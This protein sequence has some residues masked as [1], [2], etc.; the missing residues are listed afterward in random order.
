VVDI[1]I[2]AYPDGPRVANNIGNLPLH[3]AAM[4]QASLEILDLLLQYYR[5]AAAVRNTY[6][7]LPLHLAASNQA[8]P[9]CIQRLM[10]VYPEAVHMQNDDGMTPLD[11]VLADETPNEV[12]VAM[13]E[14]RPPP[15]AQT[16]RV[17]AERYAERAEALERKLAVFQ[18]SSGRQRGDL[19]VALLAVRKLADCIPHSLYVA[20]ID[21]NEL[22]LALSNAATQEEQEEVLLEMVKKAVREK[23]GG[24]VQ[25]RQQVKD[26]EGG[27]GGSGQVRDRMEDLLDTLVGLG[28]VKSQV[29]KHTDEICCW[30]FG[31]KCSASMH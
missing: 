31:W 26:G 16:P 24:G 23:R 11:L 30:T 22:E 1:L 18:D 25:G 6:G 14:G 13:L 28:H 20:G 19:D 9:E 27:S 5:E 3:Q 4:W 12:V 8:K 2:K 17:E 15:P 21:P 7:S 10:N 29:R